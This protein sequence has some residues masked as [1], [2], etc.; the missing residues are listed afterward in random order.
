[1]CSFLSSSSS[2]SSSVF[3]LP[4]SFLPLWLLSV[5]AF[6]VFRFAFFLLG[7]FFGSQRG[8]RARLQ[9]GG[10]QLG[11]R[12]GSEASERGDRKGLDV[13]LPLR[14]ELEEL[15][16]GPLQAVNVNCRREKRIYKL[17][18]PVRKKG[19]FYY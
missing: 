5:T 19:I 14:R 15:D 9:G 18:I 3:L 2:S 11:L 12:A 4:P 16:S 1:M 7:P 10:G 13:R 17:Y 8:V 6:S